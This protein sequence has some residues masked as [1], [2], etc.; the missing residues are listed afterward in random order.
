MKRYPKIL[1]AAVETPWAIL[2]AKLQEIMSFLYS[3]AGYEAAMKLDTGGQ[4]TPAA[5]SGSVRRR[6]PE[7][8][9]MLGPVAVVPIFG[10]IF[11][12]ANLLTEYSGGA[13]AEKLAATLS[14]LA[15]DEQVGSIVLDINSP[16][17]SAAGIPELAAEIRRVRGIKPVTAVANNLAASAAY[18]IASQASEIIAPQS[19][20]IG[21]I[22]VISMHEDHSEELAKE[23]IRVTL[24]TAGKYKAEGH[25]FGPLDQEARGEMQRRVDVFYRMFVEDVAA[26]RGLTTEHVLNSFGQGRLLLAGEAQSVKMVDRV[27]TMGLALSRALAQARST[28][29]ESPKAL[30]QSIR[31]FEAFLRDEGG[32]SRTESKR[33]ASAGFGPQDGSQ[34]PWDEGSDPKVAEALRGLAAAL[35]HNQEQA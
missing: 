29:G 4:E 15:S 1:R 16:G 6:Q 17:G 30:I 14:E 10:T 12:R 18:W 27:G 19:A 26:G 8:V 9:Q 23:G 13:S 34:S 22:G 31:D 3:K 28:L 2:P 5:A 21:S 35:S 24:V 25:P 20:S 32:F 7:G 33:I 11:P